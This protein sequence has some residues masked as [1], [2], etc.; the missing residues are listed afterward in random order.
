MSFDRAGICRAWSAEPGV[1]GWVSTLAC[2]QRQLKEGTKETA[3]SSEDNGGSRARHAL[4]MFPKIFSLW[5]ADR[6]IEKNMP[7]VGQSQCHLHTAGNVSKHVPM[8]IGV[9]HCQPVLKP[10]TIDSKD[11]VK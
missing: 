9:V 8:E 7:L 3:H 6:N 5:P 10:A 2:G 1:A 4:P 11:E